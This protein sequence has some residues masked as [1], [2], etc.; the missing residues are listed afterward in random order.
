MNIQAPCSWC[1][2]KHTAKP[3]SENFPTFSFVWCPYLT[4]AVYGHF[5]NTDLPYKSDMG[6]NL[7]IQKQNHSTNCT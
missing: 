1:N 6:A 4:T 5:N 3:Y 2:T 7:L